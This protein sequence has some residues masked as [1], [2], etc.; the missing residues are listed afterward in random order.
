MFELLR[1]RSQALL[2][3]GIGG[4]VGA[5]I[6]P[7]RVI[8]PIVNAPKKSWIL[9]SSIMST[10]LNKVDN[11]TLIVEGAA[12]EDWGVGMCILH[13]SEVLALILHFEPRYGWTNMLIYLGISSLVAHL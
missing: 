8:V 10:N 9:N 3:V 7:K 12:F 11:I 1:K 13:I 2:V 6:S 4:K 5:F